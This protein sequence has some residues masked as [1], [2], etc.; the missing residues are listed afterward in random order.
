MRKLFR[1]GA[2]EQGKAQGGIDVSI[3]GLTPYNILSPWSYDK[4]Y[5]I[6][7][8]GNEELRAESVE[9]IWQG[10]KVIGGKTEPSL[11]TGK[12]KKRKGR[13]EGHLFGRELLG[14]IESRKRIFVPAYIYH[15]VNNA[16]P[17]VKEDLEDALRR[18]D[19]LLYDTHS[20]DDINNKEG[21]LSHASTLVKLLNVLLGAPLPPFNKYRFNYLDDEVASALSYKDSLN[22]EGQELFNIIISFAYRFS[23]DELKERFAEKF[24][25]ILVAH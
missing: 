6:P 21:P 9:G 16:L 15:A 5:A 11:F 23:K 12:P 25:K 4:S 1:W 17:Q 20:N 18:D 14:Y 24:S 19:V 10:L 22:A 2:P 8:P 3:H 7:V 13:P